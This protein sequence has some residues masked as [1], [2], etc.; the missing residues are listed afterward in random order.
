ML[1]FTYE[2]VAQLYLGENG[3]SGVDH[4]CRT[5]GCPN[6]RDLGFRVHL[7]VRQL[8]LTGRTN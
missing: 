7:R 8:P 6:S 2:P 3:V 5:A 1:D 4:R